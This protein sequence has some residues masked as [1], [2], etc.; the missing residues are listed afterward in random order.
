VEF[1]TLGPKKLVSL[2]NDF[3]AFK[4]GQ[5]YKSFEASVK[6]DNSA[7]ESAAKILWTFNS[8][9]LGLASLFHFLSQKSIISDIPTTTG[10]YLAFNV[11][12]ANVS[13]S[14]SIK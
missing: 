2:H 5:L 1:R 4:S 8:K 13:D 6:F 3:T 11:W 9:G 10:A 14:V 7:T 12:A